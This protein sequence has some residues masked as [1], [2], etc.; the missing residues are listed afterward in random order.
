MRSQRLLSSTEEGRHKF[1]EAIL[2]NR[3]QPA[4]HLQALEHGEGPAAQPPTQ[5]EQHS[6]A[7]RQPLLNG[8]RAD[9]IVDRVEAVGVGEVVDPEAKTPRSEENLLAR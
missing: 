9:V 4:R 2:T 3:V 6:A 7:S 5:L 1:R 8:K